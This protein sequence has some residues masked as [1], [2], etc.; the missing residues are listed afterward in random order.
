MSMNTWASAGSIQKANPNHDSRT[1][2]ANGAR[3]RPDLSRCQVNVIFHQWRTRTSHIR[4]SCLGSSIRPVQ[5]HICW[6]PIPLIIL[7]KWK[8]LLIQRAR[9]EHWAFS[10]KLIISCCA[11]P[12]SSWR[13]EGEM[14]SLFAIRNCSKWNSLCVKKHMLLIIGSIPSAGQAMHTRY[15]L[16]SLPV[17]PTHEP[18]IASPQRT[19]C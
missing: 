1:V 15:V 13:C 5:G 19:P 2:C 8:L 6:Q 16:Q 11:I 10:G 14:W 9:E 12:D 17:E 4:T 3:R 18:D 7:L